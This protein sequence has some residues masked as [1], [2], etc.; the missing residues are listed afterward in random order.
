MSASQ[1]HHAIVIRLTEDGFVSVSNLAE[2]FSVSE[3]TIRRDLKDLQEQGLIQRTYG[4]AKATES[5]FYE[6]SVQAKR[7]TFRE[8]KERIGVAAAALIQNHETVLLDS[9]TTIAQICPQLGDQRLKVITCALDVASELIRKDRIDL[10]LIGGEV[11]KSTL[12]TVGPLADELLGNLRADKAFIGVEGVDIQGGF[13]V[14][15]LANARTKRAMA[16]IAGEVI[17]VADHSK[18]DRQTM[19]AIFPIERADLL[20]TGEEADPAAIARI[21]QF[22]KVIQV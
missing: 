7:S 2:L 15:D 17:V 8:E 21:A 13:T 3:M 11:R 18:L 10:I 16:A 6:M 4:G 12:N 20:I 5:A 9:G 14:P 1:R 22:T 19:G